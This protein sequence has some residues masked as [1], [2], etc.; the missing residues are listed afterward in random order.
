MAVQFGTRILG[1]ASTE[2]VSGNMGGLSVDDIRRHQIIGLIM[3]LKQI[4]TRDRSLQSF[5][6]NGMSYVV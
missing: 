3:S 2:L 1:R 4:F 6:V 5:F